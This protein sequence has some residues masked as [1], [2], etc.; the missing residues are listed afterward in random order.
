MSERTWEERQVAKKLREFVEEL[1]ATEGYRRRDLDWLESLA[2]HL[3]GDE[4]ALKRMN[5]GRL[6]G[7]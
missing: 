1:I 6:V 4:N 3:E 7:L 5:V 2:Y